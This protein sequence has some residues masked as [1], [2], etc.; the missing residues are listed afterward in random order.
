MDSALFDVARSLGFQ[1]NRDAPDSA[2]V[3]S[4][5]AA[6][7]KLG[8]NVGRIE[9]SFER[10]LKAVLAKGLPAIGVVAKQP[11][12]EVVEHCLCDYIGVR[13]TPEEARHPECENY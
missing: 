10:E 2:V 3:A 1:T 12:T 13:R 7:G 8:R 9:G 11:I 4:I 6:L 5:S